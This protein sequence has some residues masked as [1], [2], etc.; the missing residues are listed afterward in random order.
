MKTEEKNW[1]IVGDFNSHSPSWGYK[2]LD[3]RG[4][5]LEQWQDENK[6]ILLYHPD[7][8][9]TFY[10]RRWKDSFTPD[11]AF[12]TPD[13]QKIAQRTVNNQL[14]GSDHRPVTITLTLEGLQEK[15]TLPTR[16]N[17]K[18]ANWPLFSSLTDKYT[19]DMAIG[20]DLNKTISFFNKAIKLAAQNSI[21]RGCRKNYQPFW[22]KKLQELE[23]KL[24][25]TRK[26]AEEDG[27]NENHISFQKAKANYIRE[28]NKT[29]REKWAK[30]TKEL[31]MDKDT[32]KLWSLAQKLNEENRPQAP[33]TLLIN[34]KMQTGKQAT[35]TLIRQYKEV[36]NLDISKEEK[37]NC[38]KIFKE[39]M[40]E[41]DPNRN[42]HQKFRRHELENAIKKLKK[43]TS[44][45]N[46]GIT[47]EMLQHLGEATKKKLLNIFN[48]S[49]KTGQ[50]PEI[51]KHAVICPIYKSGKQKTDPK[52]YRPISLL[53]C[54]GKLME[55]IINTRLIWHLESNK[56]LA[57]EQFGFRKSRSTEDQVTYLTQCIEDAFDEKKHALVVWVDLQNAFDKVWTDKL[58]VKL[59]EKKVTGRMATWIKTWLEKR[60]AVVRSNGHTSKKMKIKNG[61]PQ[62]GILSPILFL[63]YIDDLMRCLPFGIKTALYA[64]D[65]ALWRA[66]EYIGTAQIKIQTALTRLKIW[67]EDNK[68]T[69]NKSKTTFTTFTLAKKHHTV[70]LNYDEEPLKHEASPTYLGVTF[71]KTLTWNSQLDKAAEKGQKRLAL[72]K[73]LA[74]T[75]WGAN[76]KTLKTVY[77]GSVRPVLEYGTSSSTAGAAASN[78]QKIDRVQNQAMR[79]I[80]G[81]L[82][83][84]PITAL[85]EATNLQ[86]LSER[87]DI[88]TLIQIEKMKRLEDHPMKQRMQRQGGKRLKRSDPHKYAVDTWKKNQMH[89]FH[90]TNLQTYNPTSPTRKHKTVIHTRVPGIETKDSLTP[91]E[92]KTLTLGHLDELFPRDKWIHAYTDG[93]SREETKKSGG[94]IYITFPSGTRTSKSIPVG[95]YSSNFKAERR[96]LE[97]AI[98]DLIKDSEATGQN[99]VILTDALSLLQG[100]ENQNPELYSTRNTLNI[101][102]EKTMS[103]HL[104]WIPSHVDILGN[105]RA[106]RLAKVGADLEQKEEG[107]ATYAEVKTYVK[108]KLSRGT[109]GDPDDAYHQ[110]SR[111]AQ[112]I[113]FR[114]RTGHSRLKGHM[115]RMKLSASPLCH[116]GQETETVEHVLQSCPL[117]HPSRIKFWP[118]PTPLKDKI[119]GALSNLQRTVSFVQSS[120]ICL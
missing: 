77:S 103:V 113:I 19:L 114:L 84:T 90:P 50:I 71:D 106:D 108:R 69:V 94:G 20:K 104:Q 60:T 107:F 29:T 88:K 58:L 23:E 80:T 98:T 72:M 56:L 119:S 111:D 21:P 37:E 81:A 68:M 9:D 102:E 65:L 13:I 74:G 44:P 43:E 40:S 89:Q 91:T 78:L 63:I 67:C 47:N 15:T 12:A 33:I 32:R 64:D 27:T 120:G 57:D 3:K 45:G 35:N 59:V 39:K 5:E 7:D 118:D 16:W 96:A 112:V 41:P 55:R 52:S 42:M 54:T 8:T 99:I 83:S 73:K 79:I 22:T 4:E 116:C 28:K 61:V 75:T 14:G 93:S 2:E 110:L 6:L 87:R 101:L 62:G 10:S 48:K 31:D 1:I 109:R 117:Y 70:R 86:P 38:K 18:K 97:E 66:E 82:R 11:L 53:S 46:D 92:M 34:N 25:A 26:S 115:H 24:E 105:E 85:E 36:G 17:Y 76:A 95:M 30:K 51:W 100:L 49:W